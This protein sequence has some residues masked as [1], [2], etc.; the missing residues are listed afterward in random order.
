[1]AKKYLIS[2]ICLFAMWSC[3]GD[4][5]KEGERQLLDAVRA[6]NIE[7]VMKLLKTTDTANSDYNKELLEAAQKKI[8]FYRGVYVWKKNAQDAFSSRIALYLCERARKIQC[9]INEALEENKCAVSSEASDS[10]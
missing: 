4:C 7:K 3:L 2:S 10:L 6:T 8:Q 1:M 9:L 5:F